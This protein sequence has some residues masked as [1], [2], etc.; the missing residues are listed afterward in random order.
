MTKSFRQ[1]LIKI[2]FFDESGRL[3]HRKHV[4]V[5]LWFPPESAEDDH[6]GRLYIS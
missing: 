3:S 1:H 6:E 4:D 2:L 5:F